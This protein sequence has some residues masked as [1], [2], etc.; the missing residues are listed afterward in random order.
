[1]RWLVSKWLQPTA[2]LTA[3]SVVWRALHRPSFH[4]LRCLGAAVPLQTG[5]AQ[6]AHASARGSLA[7]GTGPAAPK[8]KA[9]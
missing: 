3:G 7:P 4:V 5:Y 1:M 9:V 6:L 8:Q 2:L